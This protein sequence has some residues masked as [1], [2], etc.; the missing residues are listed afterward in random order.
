MQIYHERLQT[1][2]NMNGEKKPKWYQA[3]L[4]LGVFFLFVILLSNTRLIGNWVDHGLV[5]AVKRVLPSTFPYFVLSSILVSSGFCTFLSSAFSG[6]A[7][8]F[9]ISP[10]CICVVLISFICGFP[11]GASMANDMYEKG[12]CSADECERLV[13]FCNFCGPP[14]IFGVFGTGVMKDGRAGAVVFF[15]QSVFAV[16]FG[17]I[18][19]R[20]AEK[21]EKKEAEVKAYL[22]DD[23]RLSRVICSAIC[24]GGQSTVNII[25]CIVFFSVICGTVKSFIPLPEGNAS[26]F[27]LGALEMSNGISML[28]KSGP[29]TFFT[30]CLIIYFS[31]FSVHLQVISMLSDG[32]SPKKY[33]ISRLIFA[34]LCALTSTA[35]YYFFI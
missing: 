14:Y 12:L 31:G 3:I 32:I 30:G 22:N 17:V 9:G 33:L 20:R 7:R 23:N 35:V 28:V 24:K 11:I 5:V 29:L 19:G 25:F 6:A 21:T 10:P 13:A 16:A 27:L 2:S 18:L 1:G 4:W 26:A 34:P 15:V 8:M